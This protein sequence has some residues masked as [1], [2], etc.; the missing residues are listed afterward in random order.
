MAIVIGIDEAGF[1]PILGP[2]V[3]S[4]S[5]FSVP[6]HLIKS[7]LWFILRKSV[8]KKRKALAGRLLVT[9][10]KKAYNRRTGTK[11][12]E[13]TIFAYLKC[14]GQN[15]SDLSE[16]L[17]LLCPDLIKRLD[18]YP[19]YKKILDYQ[20]SLNEAD[21][22][23]AS[24]VLKDD[25]SAAGIQF[26]GFNSCCLDVAHFNQMVT[27]VNNKSSVLF[28]ATSRLIL[29]ALKK[30]GNRPLNILIDRQGGR[31]RYRKILQCMFP[32]MELKILHESSTRSSYEL[33]LNTK[34]M[35][36]HFIVGADMRFLPVSLASMVSKFVRELLIE[37][38]NGYFLSRCSDLKPTAGYWKDG[39]RFIKDLKNS[40]PRLKI[41]MQQL[42]RCR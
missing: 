39:L 26:L 30:Y 38:I 14:L 28:T 13:R 4:S 9:D 42:I 8:A 27:A 1:G 34:K 10:S 36:L 21:I 32:D 23:I 41:N 11:Y 3:V 35:S 15:T 18:T 25:M 19:W 12:L 22:S 33:Q 20:F 5:T 6:D 2:M 7:D 31:V 24:E 29:N 37:N 17:T 16:L 40:D